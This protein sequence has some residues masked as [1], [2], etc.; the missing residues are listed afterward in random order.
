MKVLRIDVDGTLTVHDRTFEEIKADMLNAHIEGLMLA[1][2]L[3]FV[4]EDGQA[5]EL[6]ANPVASYLVHTLLVGTVYAVSPDDLLPIDP[7]AIH[8]ITA[9]R[10]RLK[11]GG[12]L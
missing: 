10:D 7:A 11:T 3:L 1:D 6:P 12:D 8:R 5:R 4:D 9:L 2:C